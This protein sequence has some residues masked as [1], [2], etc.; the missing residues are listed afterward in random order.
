MCSHLNSSG[1][2][3]LHPQCHNLT[4]NV[5]NRHSHLFVMAWG[6]LHIHVYLQHHFECVPVKYYLLFCHFLPIYS[7]SYTAGTWLGMLFDTIFSSLSDK[8]SVSLS[9]SSQSICL[10]INSASFSLNI[11]E[12]AFFCLDLFIFLSTIAAQL[13]LLCSQ[14]FKL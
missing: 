5:L 8:P 7:Y 11:S 6:L 10:W 2:F 3:V 12:M 14:Q 4:C 1:Y 13:T 9:F